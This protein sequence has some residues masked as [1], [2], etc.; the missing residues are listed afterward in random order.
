MILPSRCTRSSVIALKSTRLRDTGALSILTSFI[1]ARLLHE[2]IV[3]IFRLGILLLTNCTLLGPA[4][5]FEVDQFRSGMSRAQVKESL[6]QWQFDQL[7]DVGP[8]ILLAYDLPSKQTSRLFK[9]YFCSD[10]LAVFEQSL[11]ASVKSLITVTQNYVRQYGQPVKVDAGNNVVSN[12]E[13]S[14][15]N[16]YWRFRNDYVGLRYVNL[17]NGEDLTVSFEVN[18]NCFS[19]PRN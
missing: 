3:L 8:E 12:G 2:D 16:I 6:R 4:W 11:K 13:K 17:P 5:S 7:E 10:K 15:F 1:V 9:Y 19:A 18:N 14:W